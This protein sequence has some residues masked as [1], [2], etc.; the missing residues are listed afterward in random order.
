M[1]MKRI[2]FQL[3]LLISFGSLFGITAFAQSRVIS[4]YAFSRNVTPG[5]PGAGSDN[6]DSSHPQ[7]K[8]PFPTTYY[9]YVEVVK[10]S[11][12]STNMVWLEGKYYAASIQKVQSPV[13]IEEN[14]TGG[15][16]KKE[17]LVPKTTHD[18]YR[19]VRGDGLNH[20]ELDRYPEPLTSSNHVIFFLHI[21][22]KPT[23]V[24]VKSIRVLRAYAAM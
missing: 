19:I 3:M 24:A 10:G 11:R 6:P 20:A 4:G 9:L 18:V 1:E 17:I 16:D 12:L 2:I 22:D 8:N 5:I 15:S 14:F 7:N 13:R 23:T 21:N